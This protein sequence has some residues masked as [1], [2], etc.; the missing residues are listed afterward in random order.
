MWK[1]IRIQGM[2][3]CSSC[4]TAWEEIWIVK[5]LN[6]IGVELSCRY[7]RWRMSWSDWCF[8]TSLMPVLRRIRMD[9]LN[10][11]QG[12]QPEDCCSSR[13]WGWNQGSGHGC[14]FKFC[15]WRKREEM[16]VVWVLCIQSLQS[17]LALCDAM[18]CTPPGSSVHGILQT[19]I[20][21]WVAMPSSRG[22]SWTR[23]WTC[24]SYISCI[25]SCVLYH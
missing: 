11:R 1:C 13:W 10:Q 23:D 19:K 12:N 22:S 4:W 5:T 25:G 3:S 20:M 8:R 2:G 16:L 6:P 14:W 17:C 7:L 21:G 15:V 9:W 18:D 24:V